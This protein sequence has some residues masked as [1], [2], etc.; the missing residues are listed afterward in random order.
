MWS[1]MEPGLFLIL[2]QTCGPTCDPWFDALLALAAIGSLFLVT[3]FGFWVSFERLRGFRRIRRLSTEP[4]GTVLTGPFDRLVE[5]RGQAKRAT[6]ERM[7]LTD[8]MA[9]AGKRTITVTWARSVFWRDRFRF[10]RHEESFLNQIVLDDGTGQVLVDASDA[11]RYWL[12]KVANWKIEEAPDW[13]RQRYEELRQ[14]HGDTIASWEDSGFSARSIEVW[15]EYLPIGS[16]LFV[17]GRLQ[18]ISENGNTASGARGL[19]TV[20]AEVASLGRE[21][22]TAYGLLL[23]GILAL[24]AAAGA[25][26]G[27]SRLSS[28]FVDAWARYLADQRSL[29]D[30]VLEGGIMLVVLAVASL[31]SLVMIVVTGEILGKA[32]TLRGRKSE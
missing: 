2:A 23:E 12:S 31:L 16:E 19:A 15:E 3:V 27:L 8:T 30:R 4:I 22:S 24:L 29:W 5:L 13:A 26:I 1:R 32:I 7:L 28:W 21:S 18:P 20:R 6:A 10:L 17:T 9:A 25:A 11:H 14:R